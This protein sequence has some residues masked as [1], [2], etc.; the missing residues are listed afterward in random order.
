MGMT[1]RIGEQLAP[2]VPTVDVIVADD[3]FGIQEGQCGRM[4][5]GHD[6]IIP[7]RHRPRWILAVKDVHEPTQ[8]LRAVRCTLLTDFVPG[9][10]QHDRR[11]VPIAVHE[12]RHVPVD[13]SAK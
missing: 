6:L 4:F 1:V 10:P 9:A 8:D 7:G 13:Q 5:I 2:L 12:I 3:I 11:V